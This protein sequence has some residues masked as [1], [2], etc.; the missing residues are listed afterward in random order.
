M[1]WLLHK[2]FGQ[3]LS[4]NSLEALLQIYWQFSPKLPLMLLFKV[5]FYINSFATSKAFS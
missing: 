2:A 1:M 3:V 4:L 5:V